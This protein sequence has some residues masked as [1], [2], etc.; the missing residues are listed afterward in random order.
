M[1]APHTN[2]GS[3]RNSIFENSRHFKIFGGQFNNIGR[4]QHITHIHN[5]IH[6]HDELISVSG[7]L[8]LYP[9]GRPE[10]PSYHIQDT[11][12]RDGNS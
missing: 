1:E 7:N 3:Q 9:V 6:S 5:E 4:D 11:L 2:F 12:P 8:P 10:H